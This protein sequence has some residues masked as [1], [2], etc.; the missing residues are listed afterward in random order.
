MERTLVVKEEYCQTLASL[1][2][3]VAPATPKWEPQAESGH[4]GYRSVRLFNTSYE[5]IELLE[6]LEVAYEAERQYSFYF[7][8]I[9]D[10]RGTRWRHKDSQGNITDIYADGKVKIG[11]NDSQI[12]SVEAQYTTIGTSHE[13]MRHGGVNIFSKN[14]LIGVSH[15]MMIVEIV[16]KNQ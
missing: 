9:T 2:I 8:K 12:K 1:A 10:V 7:Q 16:C 5:V 6:E 3:L 11:R 4:D 15:A 14:S 13:V